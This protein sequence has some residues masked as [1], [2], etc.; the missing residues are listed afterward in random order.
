MSNLEIPSKDRNTIV[1]Y[2]YLTDV[3]LFISYYGDTYKI[4]YQII[5]T[6]GLVLQTSN[7]KPVYKYINI[8]I[9]PSCNYIIKFN[10]VTQVI[11]KKFIK[12]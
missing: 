1:I 6:S 7:T 4:F 2:L 10:V 3:K 5:S 11:S 9:K 8:K 12:N